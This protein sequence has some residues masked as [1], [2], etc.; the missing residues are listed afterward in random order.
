MLE[1]ISSIIARS[2]TP[3]TN[4][5]SECQNV[6]KRGERGERPPTSEAMSNPPPKGREP[7]QVR[8]DWLQGTMNFAT[9]EDFKEAIE[10]VVDS[11]D[12]TAA[13]EPEKPHKMGI[14]WQGSGRSAKGIRWGWNPPDLIAKKLGHGYISIS[15]SILGGQNDKAVFTMSCGLRSRWKFKATRIDVALDDFDKSVPLEDVAAAVYAG[16]YARV[17]TRPELRGQIEDGG[18]WTVYFGSF[19]SNKLVRFYEKSIQSQGK[20]DSHRWEVEYRSDLAN[21]A[22]IA[23]TDVQPKYYDELVPSLLGAMVTGA[24]DFVDR[25]NPDRLDR[26]PRLQFWQKFVDKFGL[27][28]F[29]KVRPVQTVERLIKWVKRQVAPTLAVLHKGLGKPSFDLFMNHLLLDTEERLT[30]SH[31][32]LIRQIQKEEKLKCNFLS[33]A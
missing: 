28:R 12:D 10:F 21:Q 24:I 29:S 2:L 19:K 31:V 8:L 30:D 5:G 20:I 3:S 18:G 33:A 1:H 7:L 4:R 32:C 17:K 22:F 15:G 14:M 26:L 16:N 27:I 9:L 23:Y 11:M 13:W 6:K 25:S